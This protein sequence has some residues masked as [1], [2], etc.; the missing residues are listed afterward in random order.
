MRKKVLKLV[1]NL[2]SLIKKMSRKEEKRD[3]STLQEMQRENMQ[4]KGNK[5]S[6]FVILSQQNQ[7][8]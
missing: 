2:Y 5:I 8:I 6:Y 1:L 3:K 4:P 7:R